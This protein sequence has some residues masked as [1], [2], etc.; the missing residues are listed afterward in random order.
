MTRILSW[1]QRKRILT[2]LALFILQGILACGPAAATIDEAKPKDEIYS[3]GQV[4]MVDRDPG[5][6]SPPRIEESKNSRSEVFSEDLLNKYSHLDP[7]HLVPT[8]LLKEAVIYF[9][10]HLSMIKNKNY[11]SVI[12]FSKSST[13]QRFFIID[14]KTGAVQRTTVAHGKGSDLD[15]D[16]IAEK[17][18]N[19]AGSNESSLGFYLTAETYYGSHGLS[20]RLD[21]LS[22][23]NSNARARAIVIHGA[24]YVLNQ[25][26][27]QG[28][29]WGCPAIPMDLR[30]QIITMLKDGSLIYA[31]R[32]SY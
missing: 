17:F 32:T 23:T 5:R 28:R 2:L 31:E 15:N 9:D 13:Q 20:L 30:D 3:E 27:R 6:S 16:G 22:T 4:P 19:L 14:M 12:D 24:T 11:L 25:E 10:Q 29:S 18:S 21:G 7:Y 26:V 1:Q 8:D